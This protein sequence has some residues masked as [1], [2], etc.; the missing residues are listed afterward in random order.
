M[1]IFANFF[2]SLKYS[3]I[4]IN[5][6][7]IS[8]TISLFLR[9]FFSRA[10]L[11][12]VAPTK[13]R[14]SSDYAAIVLGTS[15]LFTGLYL[16]CKFVLLSQGTGPCSWF[17]KTSLQFIQKGLIPLT[18]VLVLT[19]LGYC[20]GFNGPIERWWTNIFHDY[21][22]TFSLSLKYHKFFNHMT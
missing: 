13:Y 12:Y 18:T 10:H 1:N 15:L 7:S 20:Q 14:Q 17:C 4:K 5:N 2:L 6:L 11:P 8:A 21:E 19:L 22:N 16:S 9:K 3:D